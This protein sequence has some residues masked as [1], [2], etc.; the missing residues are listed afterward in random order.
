MG[1]GAQDQKQFRLAGQD[2]DGE[3]VGMWLLGGWEVAHP[4]T[5]LMV[6]AMPPIKAHRRRLWPR[7]VCR[8]IEGMP[9]KSCTLCLD[10]KEMEDMT[11]ELGRSSEKK[12][13]AGMWR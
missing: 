9:Q 3:E 11:P 6:Q 4:V 2:R 5:S 1:E 12:T 10:K 13:L 8:G 7:L